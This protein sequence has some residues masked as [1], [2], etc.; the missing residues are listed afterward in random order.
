M[1]E[2]RTEVASW[3]ETFMNIA[4]VARLRSKD[5]ATQVGACIVSED[6][7]ILSIGY[8]GAPNGFD[9]EEFPW[10]RESENPLERKHLFVVHAERNAILNFRGSLREFKGATVYVSLFPCNECAKELA[11]VGVRE[12]VYEEM[13]RPGD[14]VSEA[15]LI[16]LE[17]AGVSIRQQIPTMGDER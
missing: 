17:R 4:H 7:R 16:I 2:Q 1:S 15:S 13:Y 14:E 8:N 12:L 5:P 11:Q 10:G 6:R 3:D 9:D